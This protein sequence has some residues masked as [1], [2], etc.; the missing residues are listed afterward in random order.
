M[1][2]PVIILS[3]KDTSG[4]D[5]GPTQRKHVI[6]FV[7]RTRDTFCCCKWNGRELSNPRRN[8]RF[9]QFGLVSDSSFVGC[10]PMSIDKSSLNYLL[11]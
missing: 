7:V 4:T 6:H 10:G 8:M 1:P 11:D 9:T 5:G 2:V 3:T